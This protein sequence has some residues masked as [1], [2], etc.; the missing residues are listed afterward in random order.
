MKKEFITAVLALVAQLSG[1]VTVLALLGYF[2]DAPEAS[3]LVLVSGAIFIISFA[4]VTKLKHGV[5]WLIA[6]SLP[7]PF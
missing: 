3:V 1:I 2:M 7:L 4:I 6:W 5:S